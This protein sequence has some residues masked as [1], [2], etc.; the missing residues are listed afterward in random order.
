MYFTIYLKQNKS[1]RTPTERHAHILILF[2]GLEIW[3]RSCWIRV[4]MLGRTICVK[5]WKIYG[6]IGLCYNNWYPGLAFSHYAKAWSCSLVRIY[7][8]R[9]IRWRT[10]DTMFQFNNLLIHNICHLPVHILISNSIWSLKYYNM[11]HKYVPNFIS[12]CVK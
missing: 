3:R 9:W 11:L 8:S 2:V 5:W 7:A 10:S 6:T 12:L 4:N 1:I